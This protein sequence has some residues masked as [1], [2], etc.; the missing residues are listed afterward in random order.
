MSNCGRLRINLFL[1]K[2]QWEF[3]FLNAKNK[4]LF[5][6]ARRWTSCVDWIR[7]D[8]F[9]MG[10]FFD[11]DKW[12]MVLRFYGKLTTLLTVWTRCFLG[13]RQLVFAVLSLR[14]CLFDLVLLFSS[15]KFDQNILFLLSSTDCGFETSI[16]KRNEWMFI[17]MFICYFN[18]MCSDQCSPNPFVCVMIW[19]CFRFCN[20]LIFMFFVFVLSVDLR[21]VANANAM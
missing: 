14:N 15:C 20:F 18:Q 9:I 19:F 4:L 10:D 12:S 13:N 2:F 8:E 16:E 1:S 7:L 17:W 5:K 11:C 21:S 6:L 3:W